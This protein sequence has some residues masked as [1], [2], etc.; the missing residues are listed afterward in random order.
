[1]GTG[2]LKGDCVKICTL[3]PAFRCPPGNAEPQLGASHIDQFDSDSDSEFDFVLFASA[4]IDEDAIMHVG[5]VKE[6]ESHPRWRANP[7]QP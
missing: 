6:M 3:T 4:V 1:M 7:I 2:R 5:N